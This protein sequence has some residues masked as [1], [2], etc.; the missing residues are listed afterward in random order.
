MADITSAQLLILMR[1]LHNTCAVTPIQP[2]D[3]AIPFR[4]SR[5]NNSQH[6]SKLG[7]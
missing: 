3:L 4:S 7:N 1:G 6:L 5:R 2:N